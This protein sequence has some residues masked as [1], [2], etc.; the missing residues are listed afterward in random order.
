M[1]R[2]RDY[3]GSPLLHSCSMAT[4]TVLKRCCGLVAST[5]I[6]KA[7]GGCGCS[8]CGKGTPLLAPDAAQGA[9]W[10]QP[11]SG[12]NAFSNQSGGS[13]QQVCDLQHV[14][15]ARQCPA[16]HTHSSRIAAGEIERS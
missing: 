14:G 15:T 2:R 12:G 9:G 16:G 7:P 1:P 6:Y 8:R 3:V 11:A 10:E 13:W 5:N 4:H